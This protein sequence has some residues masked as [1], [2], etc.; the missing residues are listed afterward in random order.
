MFEVVIRSLGGQEPGTGVIVYFLFYYLFTFSSGIINKILSQIYRRLY[1]P[2]FLLRVGLFTLMYIAS[3]MVLAKLFSSLPIILKFSIDVSWPL[4]LWCA[5]IGDGVFK[6]S[7]NLSPKVLPDSPL[8]SS[9]QSIFLQ[10]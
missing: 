2:I 8:Y 10:L 9:W 1:F 5:N 6:C 4:L 3:L 7:L